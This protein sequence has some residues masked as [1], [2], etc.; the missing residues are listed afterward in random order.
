MWAVGNIPL[1]WFFLLGVPW[2]VF[3]SWLYN[4]TKGSV[5]LA[6]LLHASINS[7]MRTL[8][9]SSPKFLPAI[10]IVFWAVAL[11]VIVTFGPQK[12]SR[13]DVDLAFY[14]DEVLES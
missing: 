2:A 12:L 5:L 3:W 1:I 10:T 4:N 8:S 6:I 14:T 11:L 9:F 7:S 13:K